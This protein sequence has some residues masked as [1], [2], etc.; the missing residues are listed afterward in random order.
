MSS[1]EKIF[2]AEKQHNS[3]VDKA[4][5]N[6]SKKLNKFQ[7]QVLEREEIEMEKISKEISA[8]KNKNILHIEKEIEDLKFQTQS[9]CQNIVENAK[10]KRTVKYVME[11]L[12]NV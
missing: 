1:I 4:D 9:E 3:I 2:Q 10:V 8:Q 7:K 12:K 11:K 6:Y 5:L